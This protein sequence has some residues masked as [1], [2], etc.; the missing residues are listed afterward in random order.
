MSINIESVDTSEADTSEADT[1]DEDTSDEDRTLS[2][3]ANAANG[4]NGVSPSNASTCAKGA[5][6]AANGVCAAP[7]QRG[8]IPLLYMDRKKSILYVPIFLPSTLPK[9]GWIQCCLVC[10]TKTAKVFYYFE[11]IKPNVCYM[12]FCCRNCK[13]DVD[14][15]D[16]IR[17][18]FEYYVYEYIDKHQDY[19]FKKADELVANTPTHIDM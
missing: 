14:T 19:I 16:T 7:Y 15:N 3:S 4:V 17:D 11:T 8:S 2:G 18:H 10:G 6:N 5:D 12:V 1:S 13:I 9:K